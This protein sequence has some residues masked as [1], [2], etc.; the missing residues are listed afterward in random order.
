MTN[1][2]PYRARA[3]RQTGLSAMVAE[4]TMIEF[5][6]Q[7]ARLRSTGASDFDVRSGGREGYSRRLY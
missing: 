7:D 6:T 1:A 5:L 3:V 2:Y 4:N